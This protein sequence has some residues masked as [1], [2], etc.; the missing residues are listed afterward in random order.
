[1]EWNGVRFDATQCNAMLCFFPF[2]FSPPFLSPAPN[3]EERL[4]RPDLLDERLLRQQQHLEARLFDVSN[5]NVLGR[6]GAGAD[7]VQRDAAAAAAAAA[8]T[9]S[10]SGS[11]RW[12]SNSVLRV[13]R[14]LS[15]LDEG[16]DGA[17]DILS[18]WP[19]EGEE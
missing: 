5:G 1:M 14:Q 15:R 18:V 10:R 7:V 12:I 2:F 6:V 8:A 4:G 11:A 3:L 9:N 16:R 19:K 17:V 13:R